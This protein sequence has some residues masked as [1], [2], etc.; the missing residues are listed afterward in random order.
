[1]ESDPDDPD[2]PDNSDVPGP[3]GQGGGGCAT[4]NLMFFMIPLLA[5]M[6]ILSRKHG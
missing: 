3:E 6:L 4:G 5:A 1:V 2:G